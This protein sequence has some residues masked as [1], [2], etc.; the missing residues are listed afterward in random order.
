MTCCVAAWPALAQ[1]NHEVEAGP[2]YADFQLTLA[3][4]RRR[5]AAGPFYYS[6]ES[7]SQWQWALP[8]FF[9][10]TKTADVDWSEWEFLYPVLDYRRFG[11]EDR[12]QILELIS[13][14]NGRSGADT[15]AHLF[16][17]FPFYFQRR[18]PDKELD[19]TA[20]A[21]FYGHLHNRLFRDDIKFVM[22]P[23]YS[24]TRK[25]DVVTDNY[26]YPVF[27][28]RRGDHVRGWQFWPLT[29]VEHK[30]LTLQTN[31]W[32]DVLTNGG[33]DKFFAV[34]P[35]F[36]KSRSGL[37]TT[38]EERS[39]TILPFYSDDHS[40]IRD[41]TSYG[42]PFGVNVIDDREK[43]YVEHDYL[44][45]LV[46]IAR[47]GKTVTRV[48]PF[49]SRASNSNLE[50]DFYLWPLYKFNKLESAPLERRRT[51]IFFFLYSDIKETNS[52]TA[53]HFH[54]ADFWPFYTYHR[55]LNGD[56]RWQVMAVLEP[57][58]PNNRAI[59]REYSPVWSFWRYEKNGKTG[60]SSQSLLWN[61]YRH[62]ESGG[63]KKSSLFFGLFKYQSSAEGRRWRVCGV[64]VK[65][66]AA[67]A[68]APKK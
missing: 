32:G 65:T 35:F 36:F 54:R 58:F 68:A 52:E 19:Y 26:L 21:P 37:G 41:Q 15:N 61:L 23:L 34:W 18:G 51:R 50:S 59:T 53:Q 47:G 31:D 43:K 3:P 28:L 5:E 48:F 33:Y 22:F 40:A 20:V 57:F 42:W 25:K 7:E 4:G 11:N 66:E 60:A 2:A 29:G 55:D 6:Q 12:L 63:T 39:L 8:P 49:Y 17:I 14:S 44:W 38:N 67:R 16:T 13:F 1:T 24:E 46:V 27:D 9:C 30:D 62:E 64:P 56:K 10:Q 45:P